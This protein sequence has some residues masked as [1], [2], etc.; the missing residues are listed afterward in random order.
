MNL[1]HTTKQ[2]AKIPFTL[3]KKEK[4]YKKCT[5][6]RN[7]LT[8]KG[9][10]IHLGTQKALKQRNVEKKKEAQPASFLYAIISP[11]SPDTYWSTRTAAGL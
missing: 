7:I 10:N 8:P 4:I 3:Q 1:L 6:I 2:R 9:K 5:I 11:V